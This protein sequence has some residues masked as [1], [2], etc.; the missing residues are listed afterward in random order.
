MDTMKTALEAELQCVREERQQACEQMRNEITEL[1]ASIK[2][3]LLELLLKEE[4]D[5]DTIH[6]ICHKILRK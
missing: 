5:L 4:P 2:E 1:R 3:I 6:D